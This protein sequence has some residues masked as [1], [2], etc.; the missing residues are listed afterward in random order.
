MVVNDS[1]IGT[2]T[3]DDDD[4]DNDDDADG[5]EKKSASVYGTVV[6]ATTVDAVVKVFELG[7]S[8]YCWN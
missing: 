1:A 8:D 2:G 5:K 4:D 3:D 6:G 7:T